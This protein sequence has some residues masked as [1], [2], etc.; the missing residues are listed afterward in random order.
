MVFELMAAV[1]GGRRYRDDRGVWVGRP[2]RVCGTSPAPSRVEY[3][4]SQ[5]GM[6]DH[7]GHLGSGALSGARGDPCDREAR[8]D[9]AMRGTRRR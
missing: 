8:L 5:P 4:S 2:I 3:R 7:R 6:L 1:E 9:L